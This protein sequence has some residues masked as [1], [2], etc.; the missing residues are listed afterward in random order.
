M[1]GNKARVGHIRTLFCPVI[2]KKLTAQYKG[3]KLNMHHQPQ[4]GFRGILVGI[5]ENQAG[6]E[7]YVPAT[8]SIVTS[9]DVVFD[10]TFQTAV[11][12]T[13]QPYQEAM[14][15]RPGVTF[16]PQASSSM[17]QTGDVITFAQFEEGNKADLTKSERANSD[18]FDEYADM[19][20]LLD[21]SSDSESDLD[22]EMPELDIDLSDDEDDDAEVPSTTQDPASKKEDIPSA[23]D[24]RAQSRRNRRDARQAT[25]NRADS[26]E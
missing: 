13:S 24:L 21:P 15:M 18:A 2:V 9:S 6:Y 5:P 8:R 16:R 1:T 7:V 11:G 23:R 4:K 3:K 22:D 25:A 10:E 14:S 12:Y 19:P 17:E 20:A 26:K